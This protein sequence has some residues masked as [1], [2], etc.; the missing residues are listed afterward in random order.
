M[1]SAC[2]NRGQGVVNRKRAIVSCI[3]LMAL[4]T[5]ACMPY[6]PDQTSEAHDAMMAD[7]A[8]RCRVYSS[9]FQKHRSKSGYTRFKSGRDDQVIIIAHIAGDFE[10]DGTVEVDGVAPVKYAVRSLELACG[11]KV[12]GISIV[13][14]GLAGKGPAQQQLTYKT[15]SAEKSV[16]V[17]AN[18]GIGLYGYTYVD[19]TIELGERLQRVRKVRPS[20]VKLNEPKLDLVVVDRWNGQ[21]TYFYFE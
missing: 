11:S 17:V 5:Q 2:T 6:R 3:G 7:L 16:T 1:V 14:T 9:E 15:K 10:L 4:A 19:S 13:A 21:V 12:P 20:V 8:H 18:D